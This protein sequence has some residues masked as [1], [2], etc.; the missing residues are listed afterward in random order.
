MDS[1]DEENWEYLVD[2]ENDFE[3]DGQ[4]ALFWDSPSSVVPL[5]G[6]DKYLVVTGPDAGKVSDASDQENTELGHAPAL[7][8]RDEALD[9]ALPLFLAH[10]GGHYQQLLPQALARLHQ[11]YGEQVALG[12]IISITNQT[13]KASKTFLEQSSTA[14]V[15][16]ADP[17]CYLLDSDILKLPR[18]SKTK[19][20]ISRAARARAPYLNTPNSESWTSQVLEA[21]RNA[22]ANLLLT[23]GRALDPEDADQSV[24]DLFSE[25]QDAAALLKTGERLALNVTISW[26]WLVAANLTE[27]L[28]NELLEQ[29]QFKIWYVRA[30]WPATRSHVQPNDIDL[31]RGYKR[32]AELALDEDHHL[33][34]PQTGLTGWLMLAFGAKGF[35][36]GTSGISQAF[37]EPSFGRSQ[38]ATRRERYFERQLLHTVERSVH[39]LLINAQDYQKCSCPFCPA[40]IQSSS[41][42]WSHG[43]A[44]MHGL[45]GAGAIT[46][47]AERDS[48]KGGHRGA[49]RRIV[50]K[51][52]EFAADKDLTETNAPRHLATWDQLL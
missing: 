48:S 14:T 37:A 9:G 39:D 45:Y 35:G 44:G 20:I 19:E 25:A 27:N 43:L 51:A 24:E 18:D 13:A 28:F 15:R 22:G 41:S 7:H 34:L 16:I 10:R 33:L 47:E 26:R 3:E 30:Q 5:D 29:D 32:L 8:E 38:G 1:G 40:L 23:P 21:Q 17:A 42:A 12:S 50:K 31:L 49:I 4:G 52:T 46:A 11:A 36:I 2:E 6:T